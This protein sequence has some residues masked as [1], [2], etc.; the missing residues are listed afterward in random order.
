MRAPEAKPTLLA[1]VALGEHAPLNASARG[2]IERVDMPFDPNAPAQ[3]GSGVFGLPHT[4]SE[5]AVVLIPVPWEATTSYGGGTSDGPNAIRHASQQVDLFDL[6]V[7]RPYALGIHM[8]PEAEV[9]R[10]ANAEGKALAATIIEVGGAVDT[11]EL[12]DALVRVNHLSGVVN[13]WVHAETTRLLDSGKIVGVVGG[14]HSVPYGALT[15]IAARHA[16]FGVL[17]FDAHSDTRRAYE[18]FEHSHASIMFNVLEGIPRVSKLVQVGIRDVCEQEIDYCRGQG[19]RVRT[20]TDRE[21]G[22]RRHAGEPFMSVVADIVSALPNEVWVSFDIDGLDPRFCPSTGTPVPGGLDTHEVV[23]ILRALASSG[24][25]IIG[26]DLN[27]VAP[28]ASDPDDEWDGNVGARMLYQ[29]IAF[30]LASQG[31]AKLLD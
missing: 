10:K 29:L 18:G 19:E 4:E 26:F 24:K 22:R 30:T 5:S 7:E 16:A 21:L 13:A 6:D 12:R 8:L 9:V 17:H 27:E 31:K 1:E 28:N 23:A 14:D 25:R 3:P 20:F 15:A 2:G 11:P